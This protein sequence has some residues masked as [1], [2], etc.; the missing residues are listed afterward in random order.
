MRG[1]TQSLGHRL[2]KLLH[3]EVPHVNFGYQFFY[4][5]RKIPRDILF[6]HSKGILFSN[7][8]LEHDVVD[9]PII[10]NR[11]GVRGAKPSVSQTMLLQDRMPSFL[12]CQFP[13][14]PGLGNRHACHVLLLD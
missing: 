7:P 2:S 14:I 11:A 3:V 12:H 6:G 13:H 8:G 1:G 9:W 10:T 4:L 5:R